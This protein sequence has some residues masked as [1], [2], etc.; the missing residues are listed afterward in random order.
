MMTRYLLGL[1]VAAVA[2]F[3][4]IAGDIPHDEL[5]GLDEQV[6]AIKSDVLDLSS[7]LNRLEEKLLFPSNS[8]VSLFVSLVDD[9][10]R[11]DSAQVKLDNQ[12]VASYLYTYRELEAL[13]DGGVQRIYT[14]NVGGGDHELVVSVA[15]KV[16]AGSVVRRSATYTLKKDVGPKFVEIKIT[17]PNVA[18][19]AI[20]FKDW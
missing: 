14:G 19:R 17:E 8:Q 20:Q 6:Q 9:K 1:L 11:L 7:E 12:V 13:R 18:D 5:K 2:A 4:A 15:G 16:S 3:S 10:F